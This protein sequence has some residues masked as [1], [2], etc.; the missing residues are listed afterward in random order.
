M[1]LAF[2]DEFWD[3]FAGNEPA[4]LDAINSAEKELGYSFPEGYRAFLETVNGGEGFI[5]KSY[6]MLWSVEELYQFNVEYEVHKYAPGLVLIGSN[7]GGEGYAFDSRMKD[8]PIYVVP[9][10]GMSLNDADFFC[11]NFET[12][13]AAR[14]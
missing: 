11:A 10:I 12:L 2:S 6:F 14:E 8:S 13:V 4:T 7:G 1:E 5:G 3:E 9:F